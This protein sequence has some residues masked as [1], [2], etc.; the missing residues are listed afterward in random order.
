MK[1]ALF[2]FVFAIAIFSASAKSFSLQVVQK[3]TPGDE[4]FDSSYVIEQAILDYFF[5]QGMIVSNGAVLV[6]KDDAANDKTDLRRS[7]MEAK[8]GSM[9]LFVKLEL[10]YSV[11]DSANPTTV[12]LSDIRGATMEIVSLSQNKVLARGKFTPPAATDLNNNR[13]GVESFAKDIAMEMQ[14]QFAGKGG[15][16]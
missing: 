11:L 2:A 14:A 13:L 1:K 16:I 12:L 5:E 15:S 4:V 8:I 3:N 7:M 6:S 10:D 9:D